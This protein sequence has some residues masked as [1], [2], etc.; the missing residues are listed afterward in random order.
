MQ[1]LNS[2][3]KFL[4]LGSSKKLPP[5][6]IHMQSCHYKS[7]NPAQITSRYCL[8]LLKTLIS[9]ACR[10]WNSLVFLTKRNVRKVSS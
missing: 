6:N 1:E 8:M 9:I 3:K 4:S 7:E 10:F 5:E 2:W